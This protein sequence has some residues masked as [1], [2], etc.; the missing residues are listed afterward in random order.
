MENYEEHTN[1]NFGI[2]LFIILF[3]LFAIICS[4]KSENQSSSS[5]VP[6]SYAKTSVHND[7]TLFIAVKIPGVYKNSISAPH[8]TSLNPFSLQNK[9]AG[10]NHITDQAL[11]NAEKTKLLTGPLFLRRIYY[12]LPL[13]TKNDLPVLS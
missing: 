7:V 1:Q 9:I 12:A 6:Y 10:Y 4:D 13:R 2:I 8:N 3:S 11:I 5:S